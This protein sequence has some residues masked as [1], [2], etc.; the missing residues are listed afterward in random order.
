[1]HELANL[2]MWQRLAGPFKQFGLRDGALYVAHRALQRISPRCGVFVYELMA[3]PVTEGGLLPA[4]WSKNVTSSEIP[5][6]HPDIERMP[7]R[8][9]IKHLRFE[10]GAI[11]LGVYLREKLVGYIWYCFESYDEDEV[12]CRYEL[13]EPNRTVFDFDLY[14][15]PE[16]RMG[17]GF[18]AVLHC[19]NEF[20]RNRGIEYSFSRLT[21]FNI[22]SR[23]SHSHIQW[24]CVARAYCLQIGPLELLVSTLYPFFALTWSRTQRVCF[25]LGP[26]LIRQTQPQH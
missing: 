1:M 3:Q 11:C 23:R 8:E 5:R 9:D 6:G 19:A 17:I 21:R 26:E 4:K 14:V 22:A 10:Q 20:L 25:K 13:T 24:T 16:Y 12:R 18:I 2:G 7:A 15:M